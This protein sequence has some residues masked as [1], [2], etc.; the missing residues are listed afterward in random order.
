MH[1][2]NRR[3]K[4][5]RNPKY[6][7]LVNRLK[8]QRLYCAA[9]IAR[10]LTPRDLELHD[11]DGSLEEVRTKARAR[12]ARF[13]PMPPSGI[14]YLGQGESGNNDPRY[15]GSEWKAMFEWAKRL[16]KKFTAILEGNNERM[17]EY[18]QESIEAIS[19]LQVQHTHIQTSLHQSLEGLG[20]TIVKE[21]SDSLKANSST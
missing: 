5:G 7:F 1:S 2:S 4:I 11:L 16:P 6:Y 19:A 20:D 13:H 8:A 12:A 10:L 18:V 9:T 17:S 3:S 15:R 21:V 14:V